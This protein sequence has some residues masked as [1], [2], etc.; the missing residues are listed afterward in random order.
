MYDMA[1]ERRERAA[2]GDQLA[3]RRAQ[4]VQDVVRRDGDARF[5][6]RASAPQQERL[7]LRLAAPHASARLCDEVAERRPGGQRA[8]Q[9][10][11]QDDRR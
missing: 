8:R 2:E 4:D 6:F 3:D 7:R 11:R 5:G 9:I 1:L 10:H